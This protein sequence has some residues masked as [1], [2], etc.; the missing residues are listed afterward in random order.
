[1]RPIW[2]L[3]NDKFE[4]LNKKCFL[5]HKKK[6]ERERE[7]KGKNP[8]KDENR[9][10]WKGEVNS[11]IFR[12]ITGK[13]WFMQNFLLSFVSISRGNYVTHL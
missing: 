3:P 5:C 8:Q 13:M 6:R 11:N 7:S 2:K 9:G 4:L 12:N 1:M 10:L